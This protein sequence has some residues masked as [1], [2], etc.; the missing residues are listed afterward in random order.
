[1]ITKLTVLYD[2]T[3]PLCVRCR[4]WL[5][6]HPAFVAL[7]Y[8]ACQSREARERFGDV[9]WLGAELVVVSDEGDVW[10]GP[11]AFIVALWALVEWREWSYR[12]SGPAFAPLAQRFFHAISSNRRT[13]AKLFAKDSCESGTCRVSH[14]PRTAAYR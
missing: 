9:P 13:I 3:C 6:A 12:L 4:D 1:V 8:L 7:E 11:A 10:A 14:S 5:E 2:E